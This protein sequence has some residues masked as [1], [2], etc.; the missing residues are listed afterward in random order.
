MNSTAMAAVSLFPPQG[1][2]APA[3]ITRSLVARRHGRIH[4]CP[5]VLRP[6][7]PHACRQQRGAHRC[8]V[9]RVGLARRGVIA[10]DGRLQLGAQL[11]RQLPRHILPAP[12]DRRVRPGKQAL[13]ITEPECETWPWPASAEL[14]WSTLRTHVRSRACPLH[15]ASQSARMELRSPSCKNCLGRGA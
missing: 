3:G 5:P 13:V 4:L 7:P 12:G 9:R 1:S 14:C 2:A 11:L 15:Q 10:L 6:H 8:R